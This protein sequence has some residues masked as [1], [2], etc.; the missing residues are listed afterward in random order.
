MRKFAAILVG[1]A[2][3]GAV[4]T[5][6]GAFTVVG[7]GDSALDW[8]LDFVKDSPHKAES[9]IL[10]QGAKGGRILGVLET[11]TPER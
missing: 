6:A 11:T 10:V 1:A 9:V 5:A 3:A 8:A 7:G 4:A 2:L